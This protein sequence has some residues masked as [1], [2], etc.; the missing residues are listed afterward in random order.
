MIAY[1]LTTRLYECCPIFEA[2][3]WP[4]DQVTV[5]MVTACL[6]ENSLLSKPYAPSVD[7]D[8]WDSWDHARRIAFLIV[9]PSDDPI[10]IDVGVPS[11]GCHIEWIIDDGNHRFASA[12]FRKEKHI[13][14]RI[15]GCVETANSLLSTCL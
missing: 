10:E 11:L 13:A 4:T 9:N 2:S 12:V 15:N 8:A 6:G 3:I 1:V 5:E 7:S 14:A